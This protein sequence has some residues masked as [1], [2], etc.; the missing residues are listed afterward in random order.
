MAAP[1][2]TF[3]VIKNGYER[4]AVDDAIEKYAV[5][6]E[7]L[8]KKLT[9]YQQE[10]D[11]LNNQ[12]TQMQLQYNRLENSIG[13][14]KQAAEN[15]ARLSLRE[16]NEIIGTA[17]KNADMI[18]RQ[19]LATA[20]ELLTELSKLYN[21]ADTVKETTRDKLENL[22]KELDDFHL[23]QMPDLQWLLEAE[24]KMQ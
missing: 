11:R 24:K 16:A 9:L 4:F 18:I 10:V 20:R 19:S 13:A 15:I 17:Q 7:E 3:R 22:I 14:E 1:R 5:Q 6:V 12:M 21:D 8:Q 23:P 2:P